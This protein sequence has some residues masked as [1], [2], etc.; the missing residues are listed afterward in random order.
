MYVICLVAL[1]GGALVHGRVL[2]RIPDRRVVD[3]EASVF[4]TVRVTRLQ[5]GRLRREQRILTVGGRL[6][7]GTENGRALRP[8]ER[9][10][11]EWVVRPA[12]VAPR[13]LLFGGATVVLQQRLREV[14][15]RM[16]VV[17]RNPVIRRMVVRHFGLPGVAD[18]VQVVT[19]ES[20][21]TT[22]EDLAFGTVV[23][24][25]AGTA[26][27]DALAL[28]SDR[29][30]GRFRRA[31]RPDGVLVLG[32]DDPS[33]LDREE[34]A[35]DLGELLA[36]NGFPRM[37]GFAWREGE[38]PGRAMIVAGG[39]EAALPEELLEMERVALPERAS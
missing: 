18:D 7:G 23:V 17:E 8:W 30:L 39:P 16:V 9:A 37:A 5:W 21:E 10:L 22:L 34:A 6:V 3:E 2:D 19:G 13:A 33:V 29:L 14:G 12:A 27:G 1:S 36:R 28:P 20:L 4:G 15:V 24:D 32:G 11:A 26:W 25:G 35:R 38:G 31:L